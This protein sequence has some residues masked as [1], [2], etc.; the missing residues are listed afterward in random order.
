VDQLDTATDEKGVAAHEEVSGRSRTKVPKAASISRL[1]LALRNWIC[2]PM[3]RAAD[4]AA[5]NVVSA[6]AGLAGLTSTATRVAP[7]TSSRTDAPHPIWL[8]RTRRERQ[9]SRC[10]AERG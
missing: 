10:A 7:G 6:F 2:N 3:A 8:L 5:S 9:R 4:G 1:L